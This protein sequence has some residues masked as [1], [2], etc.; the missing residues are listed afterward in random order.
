[1]ALCLLGQLRWHYPWCPSCCCCFTGFGNA[2]CLRHGVTV[3]YLHPRRLILSALQYP[4]RSFH[5]FHRREFSYGS[6]VSLRDIA[7]GMRT[8]TARCHGIFFA[9]C[10]APLLCARPAETCFLLTGAIANRTRCRYHVMEMLK[11]VQD[12]CPVACARSPGAPNESQ[13]GFAIL[14]V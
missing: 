7:I 13:T 5:L 8:P 10:S 6:L 12:L 4:S 11:A 9:T 14:Y 2:D 3:F 1:M